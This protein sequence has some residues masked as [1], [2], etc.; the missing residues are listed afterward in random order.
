MSKLTLLYGSSLAV[1]GIGG[2]V[3]TGRQHKTAL[4][5]AGLGAAEIGLG[6]LAR[7][8]PFRAAATTGAAIVG[9]VGLAASARALGKLPKI[10]RGE[11]VERR[12]AVIARSVMAAL[13]AAYL[14]GLAASSRR[15]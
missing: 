3:A 1:L 13:S 8:W 15:R 10:A 9:V 14:I 4:I 5:P 12:E 7:R 11:A 6:L 2:F